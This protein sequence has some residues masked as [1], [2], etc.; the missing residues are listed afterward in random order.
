MPAMSSASLH[1]E[2]ENCACANLNGVENSCTLWTFTVRSEKSPNPSSRFFSTRVVCVP[3]SHVDLQWASETCQHTGSGATL[4]L[5][6]VLCR[7]MSV[8]ASLSHAFPMEPASMDTSPGGDLE[9]TA[10][11][12]Q[13]SIS[14]IPATPDQF[15]VTIVR[16][17]ERRWSSQAHSTPQAFEVPEPL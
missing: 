11:L 17:V 5:S 8:M 2:I 1:P 13:H 4:W 12:E 7:L 10:Y 14:A 16:L 3:T 6:M 15:T 9:V